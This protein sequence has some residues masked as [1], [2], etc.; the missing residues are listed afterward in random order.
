MKK[1]LF[2]LGCLGMVGLLAACGRGQAENK[3]EKKNLIR[4]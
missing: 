2:G 3:S 4:R 1:I